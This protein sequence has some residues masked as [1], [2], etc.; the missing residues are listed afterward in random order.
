MKQLLNETCGK[1]GLFVTVKTA[2][3]SHRGRQ[4]VGMVGCAVRA[5]VDICI[6][7]V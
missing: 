1:Y 7:K 6:A 4:F 3:P 2:Q 5:L